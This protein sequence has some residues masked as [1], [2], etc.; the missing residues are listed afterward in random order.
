MV[1]V[2]LPPDQFLDHGAQLAIDGAIR[3][4]VNLAPCRALVI[5]GSAQELCKAAYAIGNLHIPAE[6][7]SGEIL[8]PADET[9][10][11]ALG[12]LGIAYRLDLRRIRP[13][14]QSLPRVGISGD[15]QVARQP[16]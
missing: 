6:I 8:L 1:R 4:V 5:R 16:K 9:V 7:N 3:I 13:M 2:I 10:E 11:A 14:L 12:R 15:F